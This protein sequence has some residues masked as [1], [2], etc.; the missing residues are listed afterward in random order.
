MSKIS[1]NCLNVQSHVNRILGVVRDYSSD[2]TGVI[3]A[4]K[5]TLP[6]VANG[7][8]SFYDS[9]KVLMGL[10]HLSQ[11][12]TSNIE[13]LTATITDTDSQQAGN[14]NYQERP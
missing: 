9:L 3:R 7:N 4:E 13:A 1:T 12:L 2:E 14:F 5:T 10:A 11:Q 8:A 6:A